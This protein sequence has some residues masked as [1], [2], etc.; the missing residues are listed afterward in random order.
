[1]SEIAGL[2][3][4]GRQRLPM[5]EMRLLLR[6]VLGL[7][8]AALAAQPERKVS[9]GD[10][11]AYEA[12]MMRRIAGEP[13]AYLIGQREFYGLDFFVT[14]DVLIPREE[15]ELLVDLAIAG[16]PQRVLDLGTGS[17]CV[18][19]AVARHLPRT[20]V[21]A[22]DIS[23]GALEVARRNARRH[24]VTV[25]FCQGDWFAPLAAERFEL[26]LA[27]PPYV[28]AGDPHLLQGDLRF[29]PRSALAAGD[30]GLE[31]IGRIV[32]AAR[33][34][35]VPGGALWIEHGHDQACAVANLLADAGFLE[36]GVRQDLAGIPRLSGA[37][38]P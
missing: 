15:T 7:S 24:G 12:L 30:D 37:R 21:V 13:I 27:N 2:L 23:A 8:P 3:R 11:A 20:Q 4:Q 1:M 25:R 9:A 36:I 18:A 16:K 29:E 14:P 34:H 38:A 10:T 17:G 33:E 28:A 19:I 6:H 35:L 31:A 5:S 22:V 32:V 26:I